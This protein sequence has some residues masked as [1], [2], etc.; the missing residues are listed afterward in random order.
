[1]SVQNIYPS[2]SDKKFK[3]YKAAAGSGKTYTLAKEYIGLAIK[4]EQAFRFSNILAV[5]FT[6]KA[7]QEMKD[8]M[9]LFMHRIAK[10]EEGGMC[11][12]IAENIGLSPE[13]V[14]KRCGRELKNILHAY[15]QFRV[16]TIDSFFQ[17]VVRAFA[18]DL[19]LHG[20]ARIEMDSSA[21]MDSVVE[22]LVNKLGYDE[23]LTGWMVAFAEEKLND[24]ERWDFRDGLKKFA[25]SLLSEEFKVFEKPLREDVSDPEKMKRFRDEINAVVKGFEQQ[26]DQLGNKALDI[27]AAAGLSIEVFPY[28]TFSFANYFNKVLLTSKDYKPGVRVLAAC[29]EVQKWM[30]KNDPNEASISMV[31]ATL[32]PVLNQLVELYRSQHSFYKICKTV[33][34]QVYNVGLF[35][36][37]LEELQ[38]YREEQNMMLISD[39]SDFLNRIIYGESGTEEMDFADSPIPPYIYERVGTKYEHFLIDEFQDTSLFQWKNFRPLVTNTLA[40]GNESLV[41]GDVKQSIYRWRGGDWELLLNKIYDDIDRVNDQTLD[42]NWRS[43][44]NI[45]KFNNH[46]FETAP[47]VLGDYLVN[48]VSGIEE[49]PH[50]ALEQVK[51]G[52]EDIVKAYEGATQKVSGPKQKKPIKGFAECHFLEMSKERVN[53]EGNFKDL[54]LDRLPMALERYFALGYQPKDLSFLVRTKREGQKIAN[55]LIAYGQETNQEKLFRVVSSESLYI[56]EASTVQLLV[57]CMRWI[58]TPDDRHAIAQVVYAHVKAKD[59]DAEPHEAF[60]A[61]VDAPI[62]PQALRIQRAYFMKLP[63]FEMAEQLLDV[64]ELCKENT[65]VGNV[66][67]AYVMGFLDAVMEFSQGEFDDLTAFLEWWDERG[68]TKAIR[69][70]DTLDAMQIMTVHKSKG[71]EFRVVVVPFCDWEMDHSPYKAPTLWAQSELAPL[72]ALTRVPIKYSSSLQLSPFSQEYF[73]E[74]MKI[75]FDNLNILYVATTRAEEGLLTFSPLDGLDKKPKKGEIPR[76]E[77]V[78]HAGDLLR[79]SLQAQNDAQAW[80]VIEKD[81]VIY[82]SGEPQFE[83]HDEAVGKDEADI[84]RMKFFDWRQN[85][86][87]ISRQSEILNLD[88][89]ETEEK[90]NYGVLVH[91]ILSRIKTTDQVDKALSM[92]RVEGEIDQQEE[93]MLKTQIDNLLKDPLVASWFTEHVIVKTEVPVLPK[94]GK[95]IRL[96]RVVLD[97][98]QATIIDYKTGIQKGQDVRQ[99]QNYMQMMVDMGYQQVKGYLLYLHDGKTKEVFIKSASDSKQLPLF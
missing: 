53:E 3:V 76:T 83:K 43:Y 10:G 44:E 68:V 42:T 55:R 65:S 61:N 52:A 84:E 48:M 88:F 71:L 9:L 89:L 54:V 19:G 91:D 34:S 15:S 58:N 51:H 30:K 94:D 73:A 99:V 17:E 7:T 78:V 93:I 21:V 28:G 79:L 8:R 18:K 69:I 46:L 56:S 85:R 12:D 20:D 77:K 4:G 74:K 70:P 57:S 38:A 36:R 5:T 64:L 40:E 50:D 32:N 81:S 62:F 90:V 72:N 37:I 59:I 11:G 25:S 27:I 60:T 29:N 14:Q 82:R 16:T 45:I 92:A 39:T 95:M 1:M 67:K 13:E 31:Y 49:L 2:E 98:D 33:R 97:G 87:K 75:N 66:E 23:E 47:A 35:A 22:R 86:L 63:L 96:D 24:N 26:M 6:N 41:V 80:E